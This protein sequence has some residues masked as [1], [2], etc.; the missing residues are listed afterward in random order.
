M[1]AVYREAQ[2]L[3][4]EVSSIC[5]WLLTGWQEGREGLIPSNTGHNYL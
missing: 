1:R 5:F 3:E 2:M 4:S